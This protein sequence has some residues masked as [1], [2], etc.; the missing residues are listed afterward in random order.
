MAK[1]DVIREFIA[2]I[3]D[4][5]VE[6]LSAVLTE[7]HRFIDSLGSVFVGRETLR[8]GWADYFRLVSDYRIT[9]D[10]FADAGSSLLLVGSVAGRSAG[11]E[12][13]VPAAWRAVV[14]DGRIA[15]WQVYVDNEPLR[16]SLRFPDP[17]AAA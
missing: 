12:W 6:G 9:V 11:V 8:A 5:D 2:R 14:Q 3:N 10:E 16:A 7:N 17:P 4:H 15:E 13:T 1:I